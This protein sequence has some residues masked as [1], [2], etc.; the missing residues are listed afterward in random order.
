MTESRTSRAYGQGAILLAKIAV[1]AII[2]WF[3][4]R[5]L[6]VGA[7]LANLSSLSPAVVAAVLALLLVQQTF[8]ALRLRHVLRMFGHRLAFGA[9]LRITL[10]GN[11]FAQT[12]ISFLGGDASRFWEMRQ[13]GIAARDAGSAVLLDRLI[14][15][16]AVHL[17]IVGF[18][19]WTLR[20]IEDGAMRGGLMLVAVVGL[21]AIAAVWA[22]GLPR[23]PLRWLRAGLR[24]RK[25][26]LLALDLATVMRVTFGHG[27]LAALTLLD[28]LAI[29]TINVAIVYLFLAGLGAPVTLFG[30]FLVVPVVMELAM[31]PVS[32]AGWG[33][34][35]GLMI[36]AFGALGVAGEQALGASILFGLAGLVF[37]LTGGALWLAARC[38]GQGGEDAKARQRS[39]SES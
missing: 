16:I 9:A 10:V 23:G 15:L 25:L 27:R 34:R 37:S 18:L 36:A 31:L 1:V 30:C 2:L 20:A 29:G 21:A 5:K 35:E 3:I 38:G 14:G 7:A 11:F 12:F 26:I 22:A 32:I 8:A 39:A 6:D 4:A 17:L 24:G 19:P 33:V 13:Q 28:S